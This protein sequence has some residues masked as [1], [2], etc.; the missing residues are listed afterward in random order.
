MT[1]LK[2]SPLPAPIHGGTARKD[3]PR[4]SRDFSARRLF[5]VL[6]CSIFVS[7]MLVMLLLD[8]LLPFSGFGGALLDAV[9]LLLLLLPVLYVFVFRP[10]AIQVAERKQ[11]QEALERERVL[12]RTLIDNLPL[13]LYAKDVECRFV[14][15]NAAH[16]AALGASSQQAILGKTDFDFRPRELAEQYL[17]DDQQVI[18]SGQPL[19]DREEPTVL[20]SGE[21]G[22]LL[23]TKVPWRNS[24][25]K[26]IGLIGVSRDITARK[27]AEAALQESEA[28][29]RDS[30]ALYESLVTHLPQHIF[31]KDQEGRFTFVNNHFCQLLGKAP[32]EVH[33]RT[34]FDFYPRDLAEKYRQDD[35]R[36]MQTRE[37][38]AV[39]EENLLATGER[40]FVQVIKTPLLNAAG[41]VVG[42]QGIFWDITQS[43]Q[44]ETALQAAKEAAEQAARAKAEFLAN[45]S[46]EIRTP[47]NG[48]IGMTGLLLDTELTAPQRE[49]ANTI[50]SSAEA[51]LTII[52]DIL[53]F[54]KIEAGKLTLE[55]LDFDLREVMEGT[56]ELLAERAQAKG[57]ELTDSIPPDVPTQLRGDSGRLRQIL[58]NLVANAVKFTEQGE[59]VVRVAKGSETLTHVMLHF[60]VQDTG[61]GITPEVQARLFQSF[62]QADGSTTRKFGGTGLGLAI[63]RQLVELMHGQIGVTSELSKGSTFWFTVEL[64]KQSAEA[65]PPV[66]FSR[67]LFNLRVLVVDDNATNR[68]ILRHQIFAWKMQK[69]SAASGRE[70]LD[71]L[72]TAAAAGTPYD[73]ALLDMQMP[74]MDGMTLARAIKADP[75]IARTRLIILTSL[76][77]QP[78]SAEIK[79]AGIDAYLVK[80]VKQSYLFDC[81]VNVMGKARA[82]DPAWQDKPTLASPAST[83]SSP[84][85]PPRMAR[86]LLAEDNGI[87]QMVALGQL[88]KL[89]YTADAVANG[90]EVLQ[91]LQQIHYEIVLMDCQMPEMDGYEAARIIRQREREPAPGTPR[92]APIHIIA[93]TANA[94]QGDREKCLAAGMNDYVSKPVRTAELQEA[95]ERWQPAIAQSCTRESSPPV[96]AAILAAVSGGI[97]PP[98]LPDKTPD[99]A[100]VKLACAPEQ[101]PV[102]LERLR[103]MTSGNDESVRELVQL[104]LKQ[105]DELIPSLQAAL[106]ASSASEL[107][108]VAHKLGGASSTCGM[109]GL[110]SPLGELEHL[111]RAGQLPENGQLL[112]E[113]IRQLERIRQFLAAQGLCDRKPMR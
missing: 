104:Y 102:D 7:E 53:D 21:R 32:S 110:V 30:E 49:F 65:K 19:V 85:S 73:L 111:G 15:S 109:T 10:L 93:M 69:G 50:R 112:A 92:P 1:P 84:T 18:Q 95:L 100:S 64:E 43:K 97:L 61:P 3:G 52:N 36:V 56:L 108:R 58:T 26:L 90:L 48:V 31:R 57:I 83:P 107:A 81:L 14:L 5:L 101:P 13:R 41:Q 103:E 25:G 22:W 42:M 66:R 94:M 62:S 29:L 72:T 39:V 86:V 113:A 82:E 105:A 23:V 99:V 37:A 68:Q 76:G 51:L 11:A 63:S 33:G 35:L 12:L 98:A 47:M 27:Q 6:I 4:T 16:I 77:Q 74:E 75:A 71:L 17:A 46:H 88:R 8:T 79:A 24:Q 40:T 38:V 44:V 28:A 2:D 96:A 106:Q 34:D 9:L 45:M 91:A 89:G 55:S 67:D 59:V 87:N 60:Q 20:P 78:D 54:S 80:P 70:A